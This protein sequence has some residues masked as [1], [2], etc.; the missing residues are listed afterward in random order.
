MLVEKDFASA[1][2]E[3]SHAATIAED[4]GRVRL[5][6]DTHVALTR[7]FTAQGQHDTAQRHEEKAHATK[8]AIEKSLAYSGLEARLSLN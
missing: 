4:I 1:Q 5:Q 2:A 7:L 3:L 6:M 8:E